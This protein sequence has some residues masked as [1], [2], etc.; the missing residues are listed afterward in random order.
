MFCDQA[1]AM[2]RLSTRKECS[3]TKPQVVRT[4]EHKVVQLLGGKMIFRATG[5]DHCVGE[6]VAEPGFAPT[7]H[8]HRVHQELF[9]VLEGTFDFL[10]GDET[11]R[12]GPGSFVAVPPG[13]VH[14]FCNVGPGIAR[15][16]GIA[17]P[18]GLDRYF[19][20]VQTQIEQGTFSADSLAEL[21][22]KYDTDEVNLVW[23]SPTDTNGG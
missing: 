23:R 14:D 10:V 13:I 20:E 8:I 4:D 17:T 15:L 22:R 9:Y 19:E 3:V 2:L 6:L 16:L 21:R 12:L 18:G 11:M 1:V 5:D 7:P